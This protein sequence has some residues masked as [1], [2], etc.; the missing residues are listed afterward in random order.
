MHYKDDQL[1]CS[2]TVC[3]TQKQHVHS[4]CFQSLEPILEVGDYHSGPAL[5]RGK[6][7]LH[8]QAT[9]S[10]NLL[11][12]NEKEI[13]TQFGEEG[14]RRTHY[15]RTYVIMCHRLHIL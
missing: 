7:H 8:R 5:Q 11:L 1:C 9:A 12:Q 10:D 14:R 3:D 6:R 13:H 15:T 2:V 4:M